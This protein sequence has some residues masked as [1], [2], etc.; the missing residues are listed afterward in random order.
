MLNPSSSLPKSGL[1]FFLFVFVFNCN[2]KQTCFGR[3]I[4]GGRPQHPLC[5]YQSR[6]ESCQTELLFQNASSKDGGA[7]YLISTSKSLWQLPLLRK[8]LPPNRTSLSGKWSSCSP[9][10]ASETFPRVTYSF[11]FHTAPI[12]M[13]TPLGEM[14][15]LAFTCQHVGNGRIILKQLSKRKATFFV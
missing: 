10:Q 13:Q 7:G 1:S 9:H 12:K 4:G 8:K 15:S 14:T 2:S 11:V 3:I 6:Q 5:G